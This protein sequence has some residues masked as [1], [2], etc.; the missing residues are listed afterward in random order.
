M[1]RRPDRAAHSSIYR[2][3]GPEEEHLSI[4]EKR[5][6]TAHS[7]PFRYYLCLP[8]MRGESSAVFL[9]IKGKKICPFRY[10]K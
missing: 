8:G 7:V 3:E 4:E 2:Q 5:L 9:P 1:E 10:A 6:K